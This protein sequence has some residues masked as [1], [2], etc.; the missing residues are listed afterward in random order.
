MSSHRPHRGLSVRSM[1]TRILMSLLF[2]V[3]SQT[4]FKPKLLCWDPR[5]PC[6]ERHP[7]FTAGNCWLRSSIHHSPVPLPWLFFAPEPPHPVSCVVRAYRDFSS[8]SSFIHKHTT[9]FQSIRT[10]SKMHFISSLATAVIV[11]A[12]LVASQS[13]SDLQALPSCAVSRN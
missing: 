4:T 9:I 11:V 3:Q 8:L 1:D 5:G 2:K 13:L 7:G 10:L 12:P 6:L